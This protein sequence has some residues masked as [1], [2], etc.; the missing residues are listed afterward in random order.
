M[1]ALALIVVAL[2]AIPWVLAILALVRALRLGRR[3]E[4]LEARLARTERHLAEAVRAAAIA[5]T[6]ARPSPSATP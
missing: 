5:T 4:T 6:V 3:V 1:E 2:L